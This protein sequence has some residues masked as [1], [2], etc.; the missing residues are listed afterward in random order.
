M[1]PNLHV[2]DGRFVL[3]YEVDGW[4]VGVLTGSLVPQAKAFHLEHVILFPGQPVMYLVQ[5]L[6]AALQHGWERGLRMVTLTIR[7][8]QP[9]AHALR[10]LAERH[11]FQ[12]GLTPGV[13]FLVKESWT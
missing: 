12:Q 4:P 5:M 6:A 13:W 11:G 9:N 2:A 10:R 7:D 8:G 3:T 1:R